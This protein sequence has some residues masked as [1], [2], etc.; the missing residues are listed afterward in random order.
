MAIKDKMEE[1]VL[2]LY[3]DNGD[4]DKLEKVLEKWSFKDYQSLVR[5]SVSVL[6][7]AEDKSIG[8]K[9]KGMQKEIQPASDL[10]KSSEV[11]RGN[12]E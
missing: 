7:L 11:D 9:M 4:L 12:A 8:I 1:R 5:F 10:L 3:I 6:L 2:H